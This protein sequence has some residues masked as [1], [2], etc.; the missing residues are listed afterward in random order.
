MTCKVNWG[1]IVEI[2]NAK[3]RNLIFFFPVNVGALIIAF[4][5]M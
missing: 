5:I 3:I 4:E 2:L 1:L